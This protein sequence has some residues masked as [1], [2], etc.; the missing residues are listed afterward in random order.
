MHGDSD[1]RMCLQDKVVREKWK[2]WLMLHEATEYVSFEK[3]LR[4]NKFVRPSFRR[5][6]F[7]RR[8]E[9]VRRQISD[10][11]KEILRIVADQLNGKHREVV[12]SVSGMASPCYKGIGFQSWSLCCGLNL[13]VDLKVPF[14][15]CLD[16]TCSDCWFVVRSRAHCEDHQENTELSLAMQ[17]HFFF[18]E[19][20][21]WQVGTI[22]QGNG[23][24]TVQTFI[25]PEHPAHFSGTHLLFCL[26]FFPWHWEFC[27]SRWRMSVSISCTPYL[28]LFL[29]SALAVPWK[30]LPRFSLLCWPSLETFPF[31]LWEDWV[32]SLVT[33]PFGYKAILLGFSSIVLML[34]LRTLLGVILLFCWFRSVL[35][36]QV[37]QIDISG[38]R[39][40]IS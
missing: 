4:R 25:L 7:S 39:E 8:W 30:L 23:L 5:A 20:S 17:W 14:Q 32:Y 11:Y 18:C 2:L 33:E 12:S 40:A 27:A 15:V 9:I 22:C 19:R 3:R 10:Q 16:I 37:R 24:E 13:T 1:T 35:N 28:L 34:L 26:L 29:H 38:S 31:L 36:L 21:I 6:L